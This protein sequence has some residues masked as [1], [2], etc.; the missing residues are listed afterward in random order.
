MHAQ[1]NSHDNKHDKHFLFWR[2][3]LHAA[4]QGT[5]LVKYASRDLY[6]QDRIE[7]AVQDSYSEHF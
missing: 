6:G 7:P 2:K 1:E 5:T 3:F 4:G